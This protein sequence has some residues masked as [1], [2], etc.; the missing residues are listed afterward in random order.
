MG[1]RGVGRTINRINTA[2][3][4]IN[5]LKDTSEDTTQNTATKKK[6]DKYMK[7]FKKKKDNKKV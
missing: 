6:G 5:E 7:E 3:G 1:G 2:E 4:R